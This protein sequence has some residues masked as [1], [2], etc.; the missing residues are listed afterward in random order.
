MPNLIWIYLWGVIASDIFQNPFLI[1]SQ[2]RK[3][4]LIVVQVYSIESPQKVDSWL[5]KNS[6]AF[7]YLIGAMASS[8]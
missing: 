5:Y 3:W 7:V 8:S 2:E 1:E 6:G 4:E